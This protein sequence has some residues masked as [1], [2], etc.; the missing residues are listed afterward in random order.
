V[1]RANIVLNV[2]TGLIN[3]KNTF[4][5]DGS[6]NQTGERLTLDP[7]VSGKTYLL[8]VVNAAIQSSFAF[9][10]DGHTLTVISNDFVP[11][12]PYQTDVLHINIG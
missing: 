12:V 9:Y 7:W 11:I 8:H 4:G 10:I 2:D 3:G 6:A 1:T 5:P